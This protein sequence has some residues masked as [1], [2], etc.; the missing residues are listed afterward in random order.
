[1]VNMS[2]PYSRPNRSLIT[3]RDEVYKAYNYTPARASEFVTGYKSP[4][5]YT[6]HNADS[7]GI[8]H[9][10]DLFTDNNG[11]LPEEAGRELAEKLR[12]IGKRT[13]KFYYLIHDM[14]PNPGQFTPLIAGKHT[15]WEWV[16]YAGS[17]PHTDH[18]HISTCDL[19]WG[20]PAPISASVYDST[21]PWGI[22]ST[23]NPAGSP[24]TSKDWFDMAT[25]ADLI[26][27][28]KEAQGVTEVR[29]APWTFSGARPGE[30]AQTMW[31]R[32]VSTA[33]TVARM[34]ATLKAQS[35]AIAALAAA[36]GT[37]VEAAL[38]KALEKNIV[39]VN[40]EVTGQ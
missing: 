18:I 16:E 28:I 12:V 27:A 26:A 35:A 19:F 10:M 1:M 6:G 25:K 5:N 29:R 20:D 4:D 30:K 9:A 8:V 24:S 21:A 3:L 17:S 13:G 14:N 15:N 40:V 31:N 23:I 22:A 34:E 33:E 37:T 32:V 36:Q 39:K 2:V 11:N 38:E 7:N